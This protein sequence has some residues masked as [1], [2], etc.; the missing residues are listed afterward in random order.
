MKTVLENP[1]PLVMLTTYAGRAWQRTV[2]SGANRSSKWLT[3]LKKA[4]EMCK[5]T[6]EAKGKLELPQAPH[7]T[8]L[9]PANTAHRPAF[10]T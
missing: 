8:F 5:K 2:M 1:S 4:E 3:S 7:L 9:S 6:G 10:P